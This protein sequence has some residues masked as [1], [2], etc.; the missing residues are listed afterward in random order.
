MSKRIEIVMPDQRQQCA[1]GDSNTIKYFIGGMVIMALI[2]KP[3]I[4]AG[5]ANAL[6]AATEQPNQQ[7]MIYQYP[8]GY[9]QY[10]QSPVRIETEV[11]KESIVDWDARE[12]IELIMNR[13][14]ALIAKVNGQPSYVPTTVPKAIAKNYPT[15]KVTAFE[16]ALREQAILE[17]RAQYYGDDPIVRER[18]G[19]SP[20]RLVNIEDFQWDGKVVGKVEI[21]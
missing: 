3:Q 11:V 21:Q 12:Q 8:Q 5:V 9:N 7:Q 17:K 18:M 6:A 14:E 4:L 10:P 19:L 16:A 2:M 20:K 15:D 13:M 1:N